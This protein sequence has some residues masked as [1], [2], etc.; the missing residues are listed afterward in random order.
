[1][2]ATATVSKILTEDVLTLA[3]A[4]SELQTLT[5]HRHDKS[6]LIRWIQRGVGGQR[7]EGVRIGNQI[8]TSR[9]ALTRFITA[10]T[11]ATVKN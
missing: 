7:L 3:Q 10:R 8:A 2:D 9:Q 5:G 4:Q 6:T 1:M 11:A